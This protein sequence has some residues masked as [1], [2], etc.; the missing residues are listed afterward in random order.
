MSTALAL[1]PALLAHSGPGQAAAL[2]ARVV[3]WHFGSLHPYENAMALALAF[4]PFV[5]LAVVIVLRRR[6]EDDD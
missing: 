1:L 5:V 2:L 3:A 4:G 6:E